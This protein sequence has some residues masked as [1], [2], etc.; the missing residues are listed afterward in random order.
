MWYAEAAKIYEQA[1][2]KGEKAYSYDV[3]KKA[4]DAHYF[5][6][7]MENAYKWYNTLIYEV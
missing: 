1:L 7:D 2:S 3:L 5:N 6:T 4:G